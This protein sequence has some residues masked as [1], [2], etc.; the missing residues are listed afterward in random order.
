[1]A[2]LTKTEAAEYLGVYWTTVDRHC[3]AKRLPYYRNTATGEV[4]FSQADL[5]R[6]KQQGRGKGE[7]VRYEDPSQD[8][9]RT[10]FNGHGK[11]KPKNGP[12]P[13]EKRLPTFCLDSDV[14]RIAQM[15]GAR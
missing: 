13:A 9:M 5:D 3:R 12:K 15:A 10:G 8:P 2:Y 1:M 14:A 7:I 4:L 11:R 6:V